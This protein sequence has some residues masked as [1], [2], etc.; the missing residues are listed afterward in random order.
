MKNSF[1]AKENLEKREYVQYGQNI[2]QIV[3]DIFFVN[4][5]DEAVWTSE[6]SRIILGDGSSEKVDS[7]FY[8]QLTVESSKPS[9]LQFV[10]NFISK[11]KA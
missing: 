10:K 8:G 3:S 7:R 2:G 6:N 9:G 4:P 5:V 11:R 1:E